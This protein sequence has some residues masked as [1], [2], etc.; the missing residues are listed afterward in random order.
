MPR[1]YAWNVLL[2][3]SVPSLLE[4]SFKVQFFIQSI[5]VPLF[6]LMFY[7]AQLNF[8]IGQSALKRDSSLG[9]SLHMY[10]L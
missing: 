1:D 7:D 3:L 6:W 4:N 9:F 2:G 10:L 5:F 8:V